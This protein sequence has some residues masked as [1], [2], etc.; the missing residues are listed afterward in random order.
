MD[1]A[2][3]GRWILTLGATALLALGLWMRLAHVESLPE[4]DGDEA[5][6]GVQVGR[7]LRGEPYTFW[8]PHHN[9]VN[10]FHTGILGLLLLISK[11]QLWL[12]RVPSL[13]AGILAIPLTYRLMSRA[14]DRSVGIIAAVLMAVMPVCIVWSRTGYDGSQLLLFSI[15]AVA[16]AAAT[17]RGAMV[18]TGAVCFI[19]HPTA[20][21][22]AP[23]LA[24]LYLARAGTFDRSLPRAVRLR[25]LATI[26]AGLAL[27]V[28]FGVV[29]L[30]RPGVRHLMGVYHLGYANH[31]DWR[32]FW[33]WFGRLFLVVGRVPRPEWDRAFW[34][35]VLPVLALGSWRL[36]SRRRWDRLALVAGLILSAVGMALIGGTTILQPGMTRYGLALVGPAAVAFACLVS[37]LLA[38]EHGSIARPVSLGQAVSL[39][40]IGL[41]LPL[42]LRMDELNLM[43]VRDRVPGAIVGGSTQGGVVVTDPNTARQTLRDILNDM[44]KSPGDHRPRTI[45]TEDWN[46]YLP[47]SYLTLGRRSLRVVYLNDVAASAEFPENF[48]H[49]LADRGYGVG[50]PGGA[51]ESVSAGAF[52]ATALDRWERPRPDSTSLQVLQVRP[53]PE[54]AELPANTRTR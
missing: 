17:H 27:A 40:G 13:L 41:A 39:V 30:R 2:R 26:V 21:F 47:L 37:E 1:D 10:P 6:Y 44:R 29:M 24:G 8:T 50:A 4:I 36:A 19:A 49:M 11:P 28:A 52:G 31:H 53:A 23:T 34:L 48:Q 43:H 3:I 16:A 7:F 32:E 14:F 12:L 25:R 22:L 42:G 46:T 51:I 35:V 5:W 15:L 9:P 20:L 33:G 38:D 45:V 54:L 18:A